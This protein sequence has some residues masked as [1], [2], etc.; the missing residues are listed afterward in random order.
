VFVMAVRSERPATTATIAAVTT[1]TTMATRMVP[2]FLTRALALVL[3]V[4]LSLSLCLLR[5]SLPRRCP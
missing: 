5:F 4:R 1:M 2:H 3:G